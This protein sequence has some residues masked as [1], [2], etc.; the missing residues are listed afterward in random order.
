MPSAAQTKLAAMLTTSTDGSDGPLL[1]AL[2]KTLTANAA[3]FFDRTF[4]IPRGVTRTCRSS[5]SADVS[6]AWERVRWSLL[7][8]VL[9]LLRAQPC[10]GS[11]G[12]ILN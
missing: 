5:R 4:C 10:S 8:I 9:Q 1:E 3:D 12:L 7:F 11:Y 6:R 2:G